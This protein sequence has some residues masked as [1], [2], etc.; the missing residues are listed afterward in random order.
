MPGLPMKVDVFRSSAT[1]GELPLNGK[2]IA[3]INSL[4]GRSYSDKGFT[5]FS[6]DRNVAKKLNTSNNYIIV[7]K[8]NQGTKGVCLANTSS[9]NSVE[10]Q[11]EFLTP[12]NTSFTILAVREIKGQK[13]LFVK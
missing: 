4:A 11:E 5:S 9:Y 3:Q 13:Y 12:R 7:Y 1:L 8:A 10:R 6:L 2:S